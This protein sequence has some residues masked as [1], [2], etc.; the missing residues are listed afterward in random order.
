MSSFLF[1]GYIVDKSSNRM[2]PI[3]NDNLGSIIATEKTPVAVC[4]DL[5]QMDVW[6][7]NAT[8]NSIEYKD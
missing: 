8:G 1:D 6:V 2:V 3:I 4:V 7:T 5:N